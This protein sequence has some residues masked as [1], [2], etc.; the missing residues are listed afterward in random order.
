[1]PATT[2]SR[3]RPGV[4]GTLPIEAA[5]AVG[6]HHVGEGATDVD[7]DHAP[8]SLQHPVVP[9]GAL[10]DPAVGTSSAHQVRLAIRAGRVRLRPRCA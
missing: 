1:M 2:P 5:R 4:V 6:Q 8:R 9:R 3:G 7:A 10:G